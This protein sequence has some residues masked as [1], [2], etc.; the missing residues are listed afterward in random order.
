[1]QTATNLNPHEIDKFSAL[2]A[3]W[4]DPNGP[5]KPLH[6]I[7]P[8]RLG[9]IQR[10]ISLAGKQVLDAGCGG[11]IL[12]ESLGACGAIVTGIDA[13]LPM[14]EA[15]RRHLADSTFKI[16]YQVGLILDLLAQHTARYDAI[17]CMELLEHVP[18]PAALIATLAQLLKPG[19]LLFLSTLN[20]NLKS[21]LFAILG[22]EYLLKLLPKGT[23]DY[24]AF[25][26]PAELDSYAREAQLELRDL[27]GMGYNPLTARYYLTK[28]VSVNY[29]A[30]YQKES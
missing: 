2:A 17:T 22:A 16:T 24:S 4:W 1:M 11:G 27:R 5:S 3:T 7:N 10:F 18:D 28:D 6:D 15:A 25:I 13:S 29:F 30:C 19:G 26:K 8:L 21:Y 12:T 9:Y 20:R 23:H 14:I